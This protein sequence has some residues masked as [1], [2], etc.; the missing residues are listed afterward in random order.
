M[1]ALSPESEAWLRA[2]ARPEPI[3]EEQARRFGAVFRD[4]QDPP[5]ESDSA[6]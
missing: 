6:A 4:V 2:N 1:D 3:T 5:A